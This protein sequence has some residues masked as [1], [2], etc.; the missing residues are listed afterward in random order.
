MILDWSSGTETI[1]NE[2]I[3]GLM[4]LGG[5]EGMTPEHG[6]IICPNLTRLQAIYHKY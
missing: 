1:M 2:S 4:N 5:S 6:V 3:I